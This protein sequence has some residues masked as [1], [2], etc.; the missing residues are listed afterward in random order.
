MR[1]HELVHRSG[2]HQVADLAPRVDTVNLLMGQRVP[3]PYGTIRCAASTRQ[4]AML[5]W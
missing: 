2:E 1:A 3:E 5:M 4:Y